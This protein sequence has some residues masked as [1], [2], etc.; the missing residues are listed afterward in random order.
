M[1][2]IDSGSKDLCWV[3]VEAEQNPDIAN[4]FEYARKSK[5]YL[6]NI[7]GN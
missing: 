5:Q 3:I 7:W 2:I 1:K 4:P 6:N